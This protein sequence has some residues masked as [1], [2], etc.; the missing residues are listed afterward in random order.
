MLPRSLPFN[1]DCRPR[2]LAEI[3]IRSGAPRSGATAIDL[4]GD[5]LVPARSGVGFK[6]EHAEVILADWPD[7]GWFEIHAE[8]Y[9]EAGGPPHHYLGLIRERY[10]VSVHGVGLSIGA[11]APLDKDHLARLAA[12]C[13]RY[14]PGLVSE[15]LAWSTHDSVYLNDLIALPY[16]RRSLRRVCEHIDEVQTALRRQI[17]L[18][19][20]STY[21]S[22][23][24]SDMSE[25]DFL[26]AIVL[27]TGC[28]LLLDVNNVFVSAV[29][30]GFDPG[31]YVDAFPVSHVGEIH[32]GGHCDDVDDAGASLLIDSHASEVAD[33]VWSLFRRVLART[34]RRPT[35]IE[36]DNDLPTWSTLEA[37]ATRAEDF[38]A[39]A[40]VGNA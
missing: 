36:W 13:G 9:M 18:E 6:L 22:F 8:N 1:G 30:H 20:P 25:I 28:G 19:N 23:H 32:L 2:S 4:S 7:I 39:A 15:H 3:P 16:N 27:A 37:Q 26:S 38:L 35:L 5:D 33:P 17:L 34:G 12:V 10:P 40:E 11:D 31:L 24:S 14:Q 29:N 21:V